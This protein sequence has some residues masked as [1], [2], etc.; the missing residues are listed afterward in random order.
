MLITR[1][2][3]ENWKSYDRATIEFREGTNAI[4]GPNGAGKS[5]LIE[6]VGFVLFNHRSSSLAQCLREGAESGRVVV[7]IVSSFDEREYEVERSFNS[8]TTTRYRVL[9]TELGGAAIAD[10]NED[11]QAW[12]R[13]HLCVAPTAALD[14]LFENAVGVPQGTY[15]APFHQ[16]P[17]LR[18][19]IFNPLLQVEEYA[20]A[21]DRLLET[22]RFITDA[23][24]T[25]NE[26]IARA[27][28]QLTR[29]PDLEAEAQD[30]AAHLATLAERRDRLR[31]EAD[32]ARERLVVLDAAQERLRE[33]QERVRRLE[34]E[35]AS[36]RGREE[37]AS[38]ALR[39]AEEAAERVRASETGYRAYLRAEEALNALEARRT[40]RDGL[41]ADKHR[42]EGELGRL[43]ERGEM[44]R[45]TLDEIAS[46]AARMTV[47]APLVRRQ[48]EVEK[49]LQAASDRAHQ[50]EAA[51]R[52]ED[53]A[54]QECIKAREDA[55]VCRT[56]LGKAQEL[57]RHLTGLRVRIEA[58]IEQG[59]RATAAREAAEAEAERLQ[60]QV[61]ALTAA[62]TAICPVCE[63]ELTDEHR[64][65]LLGRNERE[66][67]TLRARAR[68]LADQREGFAREYRRFQEQA[69][70]EERQ[71]RELPGEQEL[72]RLKQVLETREA[73]YAQSQELTRSFAGA[74]EQ[75]ATLEAEKK[76][77]GDPRREYQRHEDRVAQQESLQGELERLGA[78]E[79]TLAQEI[80]ALDEALSAYASLDGELRDARERRAAHEADYTTYLAH[81]Q[82]AGQVDERRERVATLTESAATCEAALAAAEEAASVTEAD[83]DPDAHALA[84][85]TVDDRMQEWASART[86]HEQKDARL[87]AVE[88]EVSALREVQARLEGHRDSLAEQEGL[89]DLVRT[90]RDLLRRAGPYIT[91]QLVR[92]ISR[93][94]SRLYG[95]IMGD[96]S[97]RLVWSEDYEVSLEVKGR[98]RTFRQLS[99]GEQMTAALAVRLAALRETSAIDVALFDE[100]TA[101]LDP[102]RRD[103]L[104]DNILQV[105]GFSQLFVIS[106]DDT[107]ERA[108]HHYIRIA[109]DEEGS[110]LA[111]LQ[112]G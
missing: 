11:V 57:Q 56:G 26:E 62:T 87:H 95:D 6:A 65:A 25:L 108:A 79:A 36:E 107:F 18:K 54:E 48:E 100:P 28:G 96:Y 90:V 101:H 82:L 86:E 91:Q 9:D 10:T 16:T 22:Q 52:Q 93:E 31:Q 12:L 71:L 23:M 112:E 37:L 43:S 83:Y 66:I 97:G 55:Q 60:E 42:L 88:A 24:A 77:L 99:G 53:I 89:L 46:C 58:L 47:L 73:L 3:L 7:D 29:L 1:L 17:A 51:R 72:E 40:E 76:T 98:Q 75:A 27:E 94:A 34:A 85:R 5:S 78:R 63:S 92:H 69:K 102:E 13:Q 111:K 30:L 50:W 20:A 106:H 81:Q 15:T 2:E 19:A 44:L 109:K 39:E 8:R 41:A 38:L 70:R 68:E 32:A 67:R 33:A 45:Q 84:R 4:I 35:L 103:S 61:A 64:Q 21:S 110:R 104:A 59:Q 74:V 80:G 105:K 14:A 49:A